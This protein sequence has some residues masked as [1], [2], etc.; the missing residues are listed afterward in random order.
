[1][2]A[3]AIEVDALVKRFDALTA[4]DGISFSVTPGT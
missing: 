2:T 4:V 1:M 3:W